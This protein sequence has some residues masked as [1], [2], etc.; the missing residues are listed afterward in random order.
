[1]EKEKIQSKRQIR[2]NCS[3]FRAVKIKGRE[4]EAHCNMH[5]RGGPGDGSLTQQLISHFLVL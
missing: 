3:M 2:K 5:K 4:A 1:M